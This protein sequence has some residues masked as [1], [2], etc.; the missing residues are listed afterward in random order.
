MLAQQVG[1]SLVTIRKQEP[2]HAKLLDHRVRAEFI[3]TTG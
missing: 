2:E 1:C 3:D